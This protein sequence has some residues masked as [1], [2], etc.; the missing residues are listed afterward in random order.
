MNTMTSAPLAPLLDQLFAEADRATSPAMAGLS[1]DERERLIHSK[2]EYLDFYGRL[3]DLWL[4]VS[5]QTGE[6]LYMLARSTNAK[7]VVEFGTSFGISTLYLAAALRDNGGGRLISSEFEVS[8]VARARQNIAEGGLADLVEI[9][10]GD[11]LET[12]SADLPDCIDLLLLDGAK[13]L[14]P[15]VLAL[16]EGRLRPGALVIADDA[17]YCP[18]Y[19]DHVRSPTSG[20]MSTPF[21]D[22]IELSMRVA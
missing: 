1:H 18:Q 16:V 15:E 7:T 3:K 4:P 21:A 2:T 6:L 12:L 20:Y 11:A 13:S 19:L 22:D 10:A 8:K 9:R 17:D 5:R 14:Y